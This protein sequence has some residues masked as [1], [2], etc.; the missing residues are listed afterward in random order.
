MADTAAVNWNHTFDGQNKHC[1]YSN[2]WFG[3]SKKV[4][5]N[6]KREIRL[7]NAMFPIWMLLLFPSVWLVVLPANFIIDSVV[8][9]AAFWAMKIENKAKRYWK[10]I[11][12]VWIFGFLADFCGMF[13]MLGGYALFHSLAGPQG[14]KPYGDIEYGICYNPF[15]SVGSFLWVLLALSVTMLAIYLLNRFLS[16]RRIGLEKRQKRILSLVMALAT[17]PYI[18]MVPDF[19]YH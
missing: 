13:I 4:G 7:Y 1:G 2:M 15:Q 8:L 3:L 9:L 5:E 6:M 10:S 17:A 12:L 16:F 18:M 19:L 14:I 11:F